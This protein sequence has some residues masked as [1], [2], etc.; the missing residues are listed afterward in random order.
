MGATSHSWAR[1]AGGR[2]ARPNCERAGRW[3]MGPSGRRGQRVGV[4]AA[5]G[6]L[7]GQERG[8]RSGPTPAS[9]RGQLRQPGQCPAAVEGLPLGCQNNPKGS[10]QTRGQTAGPGG[11]SPLAPPH[12]AQVPRGGERASSASPPSLLPD[13]PRSPSSPSHSRWLSCLHFPDL[14]RTRSYSDSRCPSADG[15][16]RSRGREQRRPRSSISRASPAAERAGADPCNC[17]LEAAEPQ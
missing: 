2:A 12:C 3:H 14:S 16:S 8:G 15:S 10:F 4:G 11:C 17:R 7:E 6:H 13:P 5:G 1:R 9:L